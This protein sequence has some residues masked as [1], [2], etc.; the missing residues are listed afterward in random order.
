MTVVFLRRPSGQ[1][2][3]SVQ[4]NACGT[5]LLRVDQSVICYPG[6]PIAAQNARGRVG[7]PDDIGLEYRVQPFSFFRT[8]EAVWKPCKFALLIFSREAPWLPLEIWS[9]KYFSLMR[10]PQALCSVR[11]KRGSC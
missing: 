4:R 9:S 1:S 11:R 6:C 2:Q 5:S 7:L 3:F 10:S 8:R